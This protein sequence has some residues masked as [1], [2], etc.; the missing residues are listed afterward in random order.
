M[1]LTHLLGSV[2]SCQLSKMKQLRGG[3]FQRHLICFSTHKGFQ[4]L[5][6]H[7]PLG[8]RTRG[9][10]VVHKVCSVGH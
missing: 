5:S 2:S 7:S 9:R 6:H 1:V 8:L 3:G 10:G 4:P